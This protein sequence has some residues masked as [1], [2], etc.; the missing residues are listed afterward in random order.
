VDPCGSLKAVANVS[1]PPIADT[2]SASHHP[3][4]S[5]RTNIIALVISATVFG[6][7]CLIMFEYG[8]QMNSKALVY[9]FITV[10]GLST[11]V[12]PLFL[13][14]AIRAVLSDR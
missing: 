10:W 6:G 4:V 7:C 9:P 8:P 5:Y 3:I 14:R 13:V 2:L 11:L 12:W 1:F